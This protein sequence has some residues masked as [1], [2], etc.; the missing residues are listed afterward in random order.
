[1]KNIRNTALLV[2]LITG[3]LTSLSV[4]AD[5]VETMNADKKA[6]ME[7]MKQARSEHKLNREA[8]KWEMQDKKDEAKSNREG[9]KKSKDEMKD[10]FSD[11]STEVKNELKELKNDHKE[12]TQELKQS[13]KNK[14]LSLEERADIKDEL[15]EINNQYNS[16]IRNLVSDNE[17]VSA[18][19]DERDKLKVKNDL[20]RLQA[21]E[22]REQY[23]EWR[24]EAVE[25]YKEAFLNRLI[26]VLPKVSDEKLSTISDKVDAMLERIESN[27]KISDTKKE[28]YMAQIISF[29]E[30]MEEELESREIAEEE[31]D[32]DDILED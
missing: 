1:M 18:F 31:I 4:S 10:I 6:H 7:E 21:K 19:L 17:E 30:I 5:E 15:E 29:K 25:M 26:T 2:L 9:F 24:D 3:L 20:L 11:V 32:L 22:A 23:R 16:D 28:T 12:N 13:I 14:D 27:D 8:F